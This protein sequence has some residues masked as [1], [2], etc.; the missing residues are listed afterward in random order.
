[1][2]TTD[3]KTFSRALLRVKR[4]L[5]SVT[6]KSGLEAFAGS[7][8]AHGA[9]LV[10]TGGT[11]ARLRNAGL[12][13]TDVSDIT[14]FPECL[15]G[16]VKT[17]HP[18]V[19]GGI[20]ARKNNPADMQTLEDMDIRPFD[21]IVVNL[22]PFRET[23]SRS[24]C[25]IEEAIENIDIGG[26][27]MIRA[28]AKNFDSVCVVT[29]PDQYQILTGE[30]E[31]FGGIR[32]KTRLAF[33]REAFSRTA[34][35][36]SWI[37]TYLGSTTGELLPPRLT[38]ALDKSGDLRYG[39]N[40]H[41]EA[42]VYGYQHEMIDCFHGKQLS[43]NNYL[44]VDAALN[45]AA[46]FKDDDPTCIIIKHTNPC[47]V[48]TAG[49]LEQAWHRAFE[50]DKNS[51]FGGIVAVNKTLDID[52]ARAIDSI[53]TEIVLAPAYSDE[54]LELLRVKANRRLI[55][56]R[57][58]E[59][60]KTSWNTRGIFGGILYQQSDLDN[61]DL[62]SLK[63]VTERQPTADELHDLIFAWKVVR[64][65]S[66]NAIVFA[67]NR[68]TLGIGGGQTSRVESSRIAVEKAVREQL[69]LENSVIASDAF[70]PFADGIEAAALAGAMAV[71]QPGGSMRDQEVIDAAN[72]NGMAMVFTGKRHFRH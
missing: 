54:A 29:S 39:E 47:G 55:I 65:V 32:Y 49:S 14:G 46:L 38:L 57:K 42:G 36:D 48:A 68:Q 26:P 16:R 64:R 59:L 1:M 2:N 41:Q 33:A 44:D 31:E 3:L 24:G 9:E 61:L 40:P 19:H 37:G 15:D 30:I 45:M 12:Q 56:Y 62:D 60:L 17:L 35:Y 22:Y 69:D 7:L 43:Y 53:F 20:L 27:A 5:L 70:F 25:T 34:Q 13:V 18:S 51:P 28:A 50:T 23:I 8:N 6:D 67:R 52:A 72:R 4:V 66:S 11:A 21:L 71:I 10:S 58:T 63:V